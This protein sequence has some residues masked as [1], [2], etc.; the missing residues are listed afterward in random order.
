MSACTGKE[1]ETET[2]EETPEQEE[3]AQQP[4]GLNPAI[5]LAGLALIGGGGA[6]AY[7]K[8]GKSRPKTK[9]NDNLDDYDYGEDEY[10]FEP[11]EDEPEQDTTEDTNA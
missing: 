4:A 9:G 8:L 11:Y 3:P 1:Q 10:E 5:L 7:F 6:F 2:P